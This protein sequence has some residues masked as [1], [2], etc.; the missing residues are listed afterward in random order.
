MAA[1]IHWP[2]KVIAFSANGVWMQRYELSQAYNGSSDQ[3]AM[4]A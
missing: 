3:A 1:R 2:L 4:V